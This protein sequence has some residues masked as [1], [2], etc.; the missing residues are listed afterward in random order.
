MTEYDDQAK[1]PQR[2]Y[3]RT[4]LFVSDVQRAA[5]FY[6]TQL[7]FTKAWHEADGKG[8]VCQ[9]NRGICEIIL[10]ADAKRHDR[11]RLFIELTKE[12]MATLRQELAE[13]QVPH[14]QVWWGYDCLQILDPDGNELLF[15]MD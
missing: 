13:R 9:V 14:R 10:C 15:P 3:T 4:V 8:T 11:A 12:G 7:G 1:N 2:W 5:Q 6:M